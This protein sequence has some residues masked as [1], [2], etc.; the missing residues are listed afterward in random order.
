MELDDA[1]EEEE[2]IKELLGAGLMVYQS[3][4][5]SKLDYVS[6]SFRVLGGRVEESCRIVKDEG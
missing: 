6:Q 3:I 1:G 4:G 2:A 5:D